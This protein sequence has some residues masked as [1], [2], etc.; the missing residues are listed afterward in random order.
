MQIPVCS[1][2]F[3]QPKIPSSNPNASLVED[4]DTGE[5]TAERTSRSNVSPGSILTRPCSQEVVNRIRNCNG[6]KKKGSN[7]K[8]GKPGKASIKELKDKYPLDQNYFETEEAFLFRYEYK[9][10]SNFDFDKNL[11]E[12]KKEKVKF[13]LK[14]D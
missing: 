7:V 11:S 9:V 2:P 12:Y 14:V 4:L 3:G 6:S 10:T 5:Q 1:S 13:V 8:S